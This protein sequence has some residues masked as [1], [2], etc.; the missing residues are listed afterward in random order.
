MR[1]INPSAPSV[2]KLQEILIV[3][4]PIRAMPPSRHYLP[5]T[6]RCIMAAGSNYIYSDPNSFSG[7]ELKHSQPPA[8]DM[9]PQRCCAHGRCHQLKRQVISACPPVGRVYATASAPVMDH[10]CDDKKLGYEHAGK[11]D[12]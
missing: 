1:V 9:V 2:I 8:G 11:I 12:S 3:A 5:L 4:A 7:G 6:A 10:A